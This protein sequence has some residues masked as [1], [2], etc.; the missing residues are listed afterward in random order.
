MLVWEHAKAKS[1]QQT[2]VTPRRDVWWQDAVARQCAECP[3]EWVD[4][5][6]PLFLLYTSGSTGK[7]KGVLHS[8]GAHHSLGR[9]PACWP[10]VSSHSRCTR[11]EQHMLVPVWESLH[12]QAGIAVGNALRNCVL[13]CRKEP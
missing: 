10:H 4:A 6:D 2:P 11:P 1:R 9:M 8:N 12:R 5:E 3:P 13:P 7:P